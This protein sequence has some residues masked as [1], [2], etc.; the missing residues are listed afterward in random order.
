MKFFVYL[1]AAFWAVYLMFFGITIGQIDNINY[2]IF[3]ILDGGMIF[4]MA[5]DFLTR[6][7]MQETPAQ[8]TK[9]Y[10][11]L[12]VKQQSI[13]DVFLIRLAYSPLNWF[14]LFFW[15]PF[16]FFTVLHFYGFT[17]FV[18]YNLGWVLLYVLNG[19]WFLFWRTIA[20]TNALFYVIP[21][22]FHAIP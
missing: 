13:I 8:R 18:A 22:L 1:F 7:T 5:L 16:S 11:L 12:P 17:G 4:A 6:L 15:V 9:P 21:I 14:W 10:K 19:H 3:D 2:E 20:S